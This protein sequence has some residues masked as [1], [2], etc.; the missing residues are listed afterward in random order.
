MVFYVRSLQPTNVR[1]EALVFCEHLMRSEKGCSI[2]TSL[3]CE[4]LV[5]GIIDAMSGWRLSHSEKVPNDHIPLVTAACRMALMTRWPGVHHAY[6]WKLGIDNVL[7]DLLLGNYKRSCQLNVPDELRAA[8]CDN[9]T[10]IRNYI[11]DILGW[12]A[13]HCDY[14]FHSC[15]EGKMS[16]LDTLI[17]CACLLAGDFML[18]RCHSQHH[19]TLKSSRASE[20][21]PVSRAVM[22]MILSSCNYIASRARDLLWEIISIDK[23]DYLD[24][25]LDTLKLIFVDDHSM[26]SDNL[27]TVVN[28]MSLVYYSSLPQCQ[29]L[30]LE[31]GGLETLIAIIDRCLNGGI[32]VNRSSIAPHLYSSKARTCC[33][34]HVEEQ[35]GGNIIL[36]YSLQALSQLISLFDFTNNYQVRSSGQN[37]FGNLCDN[38]KARNLFCNLQQIV[39]DQFSHEFQ[40]YATYCLS[41][42]GFYGFP[43]KLGR[44]MAGALNENE[45]ADLQ[46]ILSNEKSLG[47]HGAILMA[48]CPALLPSQSFPLK[49]EALNDVSSGKEHSLQHRATLRRGIHLSNHV[50]SDA[51]IKLLE[52]VYTGYCQVDDCIL[53]PLLLLAKRCSVKS[54]YHM[55]KRKHARCGT[56][57]PRCDFT[58]LLALAEHPFTDITLEAKGNEKI[59]DCSTCQ[60]S[61]PHMHV[62]K[63]I[64]CSSSAY[65][66]ALFHSG[67][68][69]SYS[70]HIKV[71][72]CWEALIKLV[73]W[74]Y[75]GELPKPEFYCAW[76]NMD[77][78]QQFKELLVYVELSWLA[79]F[80]CLDD[81]HKESLEVLGS[82]FRTNQNFP[83]KIVESALGLSQW[84]IVKAAAGRLA[85]QYPRMRDAGDLEGINEE[86]VQVLQSEYAHYS[87]ESQCS[88]Y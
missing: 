72:I 42:F 1:I 15:N 33:W 23:S 50:H 57:I 59:R 74:F 11:W 44:R 35:K 37:S 77:L 86:V 4:P 55:L 45:L 40:W 54:L 75:S 76:K 67:M 58:H 52:F 28:L 70:Q 88:C 56:P 16:S 22:M 84:E 24:C 32:H 43:S 36:L 51:L 12:L 29:C 34:N 87:Q 60:M 73:D 19:S 7:L 39:S 61:L 14:D 2:L 68:Q 83:L 62:H 69:E 38:S 18:M 10:D 5:Q 79:E 17:H 3:C 47:V 53:K 25:L 8:T 20:L 30:V 64:L 27:E 82:C 46:L 48:R 26:A 49:D 66:Q 85:P 71:P 80:W 81:V 6:F 78:E 41:S 31:K 13:I 63:I 21:E 65:M 9:I